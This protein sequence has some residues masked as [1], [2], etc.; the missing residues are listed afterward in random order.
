METKLR[1]VKKYGYSVLAILAL[2]FLALAVYQVAIKDNPEIS[3]SPQDDYS[4]IYAS[5]GEF[6]YGVELRWN[7]VE[8]ESYNIY[9]SKN[10]EDKGCL[11]ENILIKNVGKNYFFDAAIQSKKNYYYYSVGFVIKDKVFCSN[12]DPGFTK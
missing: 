4:S 8:S 6:S 3:L 10:S 9:R 11:E 7:N 1:R 12:V 5:N 2:L